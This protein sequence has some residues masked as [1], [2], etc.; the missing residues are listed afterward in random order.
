MERLIELKQ[1][2]RRFKHTIG[3]DTLGPHQPVTKAEF[4]E[5][6]ELIFENLLFLEDY[7]DKH[8]EN[9]HDA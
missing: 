6:M 3:G 2:I 8:I 9:M 4:L 7:I 1:R 5:F